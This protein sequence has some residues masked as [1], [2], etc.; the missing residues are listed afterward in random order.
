VPIVPSLTRLSIAAAFILT[1][2]STHAFCQ[3]SPLDYVPNLPYKAEVVQTQVL[4]GA[5][6]T[7]VQRETKLVEARDSQ[8]KNASNHSNRVI[9]VVR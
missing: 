2:C 5:N 4:P 8:G 9:R 1:S 6:G 3:A 7:R